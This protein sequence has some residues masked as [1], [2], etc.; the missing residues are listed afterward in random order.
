MSDSRPYA[1]RPCLT[2]VKDKFKLCTSFMWVSAAIE[3]FIYAKAED[4][5]DKPS[6]SPPLIGGITPISASS[7]DESGDWRTWGDS[8]VANFMNNTRIEGVV[9]VFGPG[10]CE[11][12]PG[13][14]E[15]KISSVGD[16]IGD[17]L[18]VR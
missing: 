6:F 14:V 11:E 16:N 7:K 4:A 13:L 17:S 2:R 5:M 18:V 10:F 8:E 15:R 1:A 3:R 9:R 12:L